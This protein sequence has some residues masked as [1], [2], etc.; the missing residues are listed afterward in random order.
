MGAGGTLVLG[1]SASLAWRYATGSMSDYDRYTKI[2]RAPPGEQPPIADLL[3]YAAL[4]A[5][6][7]NTQPWDFSVKGGRIDIVPDFGRRT[8]VVDPDDHHLFVSLGCLGE[9]LTIAARAVG[10]PGDID[11]AP[12]G[13]KLSFIFGEGRLV[14][15]PL[16]EA[17]G[18]RQSTRSLYDGRPVPVDD[19]TALQR[20]AAEPGVSLFLL[21]DRSN[22]S[23]MRD[24]I[25]AGNDAQMAE[26]AFVKEL[27]H[28]IRFNPRGAMRA[29]DG[30]FSGA[31]GNPS[32]P[33]ILADP[34]FSLFVTRQS[35][36]DKYARQIKSTPT[37]AV[38]VGD[39][40][41]PLHWIKIGRACQRFMLAATARGLKIACVNQPVEVPALRP[42]LA[43]LVGEPDRR[44]DLVLRLGYA[45]ALPYSPRRPVRL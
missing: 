40:A 12:N 24:L 21:T 7:H 23:R 29:G 39:K 36:N 33:D 27:K 9:N 42:E 35:E 16:F 22:I 8:P 6:G 44:P 10:Y 31:S 11:V 25:V 13:G 14:H 45:P 34:A 28:W 26:S 37:L 17:I 1:A 5:S 20:L 19:L 2:L 32:L 30:L 15:D 43:A 18:L 41:D 38:F 4:A 3:R